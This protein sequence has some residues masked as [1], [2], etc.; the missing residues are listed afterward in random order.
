MFERT[1]L[2]ISKLQSSYESLNIAET[3]N[4]HSKAVKEGL[5]L[6][7]ESDIIFKDSDALTSFWSDIGTEGASALLKVV[8]LADRYDAEEKVV[9][10]IERIFLLNL[11]AIENYRCGRHGI[12]TAIIRRGT[13][14]IPDRYSKT[15]T[16]R[17][18]N[19]L[20]SLCVGDFQ[21][22]WLTCETLKKEVTEQLLDL[23]TNNN[24]N[25]STVV[26]LLLSLLSVVE[27]LLIL[28]RHMETGNEI[29][30]TTEK[31][32]SNVVKF[33]QNSG[34]NEYQLF[35]ESF[36]RTFHSL[37]KLSIWNIRKTYLHENN[38][39][40]IFVS[41]AQHRV[42]SRKPFLFPS[43]YEALI[44]HKSL[45]SK[46]ELV[47]MPTG[48][49]KTLVSE[50]F[51]LMSF[52][53][54]PEKKCLYIV[55]TR[56][57]AAEKKDDLNEAFSWDNSPFSVCRMTGDVAFDVKEALVENNVIILTPEK[58]DIL[59][60]NK[61]YGHRISAMVVDEFH[62]I[63][64]SYR[65]IKLQLSVKRFQKNYNAAVIYISAIL[66]NS[67]L[68]AIS[69]WVN[70]SD[71]FTSEWR[72]TPSRIGL[73]SVNDR[74]KT[75]VSFN[76]GT[77][78]EISDLNGIR[79]NASNQVA[80]R[81]VKTFL[82]T[83]QDQVLHFNL[84]WRTY[85]KGENR[86]IE[87]AKEYMK[88]IGKPITF[89]AQKLE[90]LS[91]K[92]TRL[93]G[94]G[95]PLELAFRKGIAVHWGELPHMARSIEEAAIRERAIG[96]ILS[97]STLA[98]GVNLPI[99]TIF[100]PK[101]STRKWPLEKGL[102]LN[103]IGRAGRPYFHSEGQ[104]VIAFNERG[105]KVDR[106]PKSKAEEYANITNSDIEPII[107]SVVK[108]GR[109]VEAMRKIPGI[110][111]EGKLE[112]EPDWEMRIDPLQRRGYQ[113][114]L[115]E[116][117]ALSSNLLA[118][119][120]EGLISDVS[121]KSIENLIFLGPET[122]EQRQSV[123]KLLDL[124]EK[125]LFDFG[126]LKQVGN[127]SKVTP[128]GKV[129]YATGLGPV[130]CQRLRTFAKKLLSSPLDV[131]IIGRDLIKD[132]TKSNLFAKNLLKVI[133]IPLE[134]FV[135]GE[136]EFRDKDE[137]LLLLWIAG[138]PLTQISKHDFELQS[139]FLKTFMKLE[140]I[141]SGYTSWILEALYLV[142]ESEIQAPLGLRSIHNMAKY[143]LYGH[144]DSYV[145]KLLEKDINKT[146]LRDD[147]IV[148]KDTLLKFKDLFERKYDTEYL[149]EVLAKAKQ[150][151]RMDEK[152]VVN[153]LVKLIS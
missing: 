135:F 110:W 34:D 139:N 41:W 39:N 78:R 149:R 50:V 40:S 112:P 38:D 127:S 93:V 77:F 51:I 95:D 74:P 29:S 71:P 94:V 5:D 153:S 102:F 64:T 89:N 68:S 97:T 105:K 148:L 46:Q 79:I 3:T 108:V 109:A 58:L 57:L 116:V 72:P 134:K 37:E 63:R 117:E 45:L 52:I 43:Q 28:R 118:C 35:A 76:D 91:V 32:L 150:K 2:F 99:K 23:D 21:E 13:S 100:V 103:I 121:F 140:G 87:L 8:E 83:E 17:I 16:G 56:A 90:E 59:M 30:N 86:L 123:K 12:A 65:G 143:V 115:A 67:D 81:I 62:T 24:Q 85:R 122:D 141:L 66:R 25:E 20:R 128:W 106:T 114:T 54:F 138:L 133:H 125:R 75:V 49:G 44:A 145:L 96:L 9:P 69:K 6:I 47:T 92:F 48:G 1:K 147:V 137:E 7:I 10:R 136:G 4:L 82:D 53:K 60:R 11:A 61:F 98:E 144:F 119:V 36:V 88:E 107:S 70:S 19:L 33:S 15:P 26:Q 129:V 42:N 73:V 146:L 131:R 120:S 151:T 101:L 124:V 22:T 31:C 113:R 130:S 132:G 111:S 84:T 104:V 27:S 142:S 80:I 126:V 14:R 18:V 152:E 55:P